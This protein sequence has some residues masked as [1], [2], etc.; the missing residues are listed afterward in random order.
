M[1]KTRTNRR[2]HAYR[3][4]HH[5]RGRGANAGK[6]PQFFLREKETGAA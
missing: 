1:A 3:N 2:S 6:S 5:C 4:H